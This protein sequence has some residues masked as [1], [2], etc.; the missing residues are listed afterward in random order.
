MCLGQPR[1]CPSWTPLGEI[2]WCESSTA[3][4]VPWR[5]IVLARGDPSHIRKMPEMQEREKGGTRVVTLCLWE[6]SVWDVPDHSSGSC[7]LFVSKEYNCLVASVCSSWTPAI[8]LSALTQR[9][10]TRRRITPNMHISTYFLL[11][12]WMAP[13]IH[14]YAW[15]GI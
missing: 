2:P 5:G 10:A 9:Q 8:D 11:V 13:S 3:S 6:G 7:V 14:I 4:F 12:E 1:G 15:Y